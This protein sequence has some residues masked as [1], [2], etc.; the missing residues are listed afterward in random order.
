MAEQAKADQVLTLRKEASEILFQMRMLN[1]SGGAHFSDEERKEEVEFLK[2]SYL[3]KKKEVEEH[4]AK[5]K[6]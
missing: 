6:K 3:E 5:R 4:E 1:G 2:K